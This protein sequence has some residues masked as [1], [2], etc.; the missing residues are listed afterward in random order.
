[1]DR[2]RL[3]Q[4]GDVHFDEAQKR[5]DIDTKDAGVAEALADALA[6]QPLEVVVRQMTMFTDIDALLFCGDLTSY[7]DLGV[8]V[9]SL[10]YL[11]SSLAMRTRVEDVVHAVPGNHDIDRDLV[12]PDSSGDLLAKFT[13]LVN[14]WKAESIPV[15]ATSAIRHTD[16]AVGNAC[17]RIFSANSCIGCGEHRRQALDPAFIRDLEDRSA[18]GDLDAKKTL[19]EQLDAPMFLQEDV[20]QLASGVRDMSENM[21]PVVLAH[22]NLLP[23]RIVRLQ[24]YGEMVNSGIV[25][26]SLA[27]AAYP[28]IY[29][30][31]HIHDDPIELIEQ[32]H[33]RS[34][35]VIS[36]AAPRLT[37][38][39]NV[40]DLLC[41][42][43]GLPLGVVVRRW[44]YQA[45]GDITPDAP[46]KVPLRQRQDACHP[47][48]GNVL[49]TLEHLGHCRW[50]SFIETYRAQHGSEWSD[51]Q[52][53]DALLEAQWAGLV[54][55]EN[56]E[57]PA[58]TWQL[59]KELV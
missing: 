52:I 45:G 55:I 26:T 32:V 20:A 46:V 53:Q 51:E 19:Y 8:Y 2:V 28:V 16:V 7:G 25:R 17:A 43:Q 48:T 30:H 57:R 31:G 18:A 1:M 38:G 40:I 23:Q 24:P 15:L 12:D 27:T 54:A 42:H 47:E 29:L 58:R 22:H 10:R 44:R 9:D 3:L 35:K 59:R 41:G 4:V 13:P 56:E 39:F 14:A 5:R 49:D 33:P 11:E 50:K 37:D 6:P 21:V 34:G 36:I